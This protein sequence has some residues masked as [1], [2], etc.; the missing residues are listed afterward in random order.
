[1]TDRIPRLTFLLQSASYLI[2][3]EYVS[4]LLDM[5]NDRH[6]DADFREQVI[7]TCLSQ[8]GA[9]SDSVGE[10][11]YPLYCR[12][13]VKIIFA[14]VPPVSSDILQLLNHRLVEVRLEAMEQLDGKTAT[15]DGATIST[16][17]AKLSSEGESTQI[18]SLALSII[19]HHSQTAGES[20]LGKMLELYR[21]TSEDAVRSAAL[22]A[23]GRVIE[24]SNDSQK[25]IEW[26]LC[27][28]DAIDSDFGLVAIQSIATN[29]GLLKVSNECCALL[30]NLWHCLLR[31]LTDDDDSVRLASSAVV[32]QV[33]NATPVHPSVAL[34]AALD[35]FGN[36]I[37]RLY[38]V[39]VITTLC[40]LVLISEEQTTPTECDSQSF[41]K[42]DSDA[43][44]EPLN[45]SVLYCRVIQRVASQFHVKENKDTFIQLLQT[46]WRSGLENFDHF[47]DDSLASP[48]RRPIQSFIV[49]LLK[50]FLL[51]GALYPLHP[52]IATLYRTAKQRF[53][54]I[55]IC[56][57]A[58]SVNQLV[59]QTHSV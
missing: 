36:C 13:L 22:T 49:D 10:P 53:H 50:L 16:L 27:L 5:V 15:L 39:Q 56:W 47:V 29:H 43:F 25:R 41:E 23:A 11:F 3:F 46:F 6:L 38:P 2:R 40:H 45:H 59:F 20:F 14:T 28:M 18:R 57:I 19:G 32:A 17:E 31:C 21:S 4:I 51:S 33:I 48:F 9:V 52:D 12:S 8:L 42:D 24:T 44:Y 58:H 7:K 37:G 1:M 54:E 35:H 55:P 30:I 34:D 26:S